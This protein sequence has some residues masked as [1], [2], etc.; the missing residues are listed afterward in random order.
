M[1]E[2]APVH[3]GTIE[4]SATSAAKHVGSLQLID[5]LRNAVR[6]PNGAVRAVNLCVALHAGRSPSRKETNPVHTG[7]HGNTIGQ[8]HTKC[9]CCL[10]VRF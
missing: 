9:S 1:K 5:R 4:G 3:A 2:S 8:A 10:L 6:C 7:K